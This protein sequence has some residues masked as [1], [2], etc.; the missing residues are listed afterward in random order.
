MEVASLVTVTME[1][2]VGTIEGE[3]GGTVDI[4][5]IIMMH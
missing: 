1:G 3:V 4:L 5:P 2:E